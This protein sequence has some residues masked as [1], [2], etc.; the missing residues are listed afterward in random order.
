MSF[1]NALVVGGCI[2]VLAVVAMNLLNSAS[3]R[4]MLHHERMTAIEKGVP[5]PEDLLTDAPA[6]G[7]QPTAAAVAG[8]RPGH[9][10]ARGAVRS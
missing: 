3:R 1:E 9:P 4:Y 6:E 10:V 8:A 7:T 2:A 5:L